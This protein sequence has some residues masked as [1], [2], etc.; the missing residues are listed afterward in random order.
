MCGRYTLRDPAAVAEV[1]RALGTEVDT[2]PPVPRFNAA[3]SQTMPAVLGTDTGPRYQNLRWGIVPFFARKD[4]KPLQLINARS[5][6]A[7]EKPSF[8][9]SIQK[10]RC[11]LPAD[12]FFEWKREPEGRSK[13]PFFIRRRD[14]KP[15]L[16]AGIYEEASDPFP[17]G[18]ALLTTGPNEL[19]EPIHH[20]M[21]VILDL[22]AARSWLST[23]PIEPDQVRTICVSYPAALMRADPVSPIVNN[24][25]NDSPDCV[26]P[27]AELDFS[28]EWG[29]PDQG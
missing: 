7:A 27:L 22:E 19:M 14:E 13:T 17:A 26:R 12:G 10:R 23:G 16:I 11:V 21:P 6:T 20:R 9:Q 5:E 2:P 18:F 3:P 24:A 28:K 15:F 8:R 29:R 25:R 1:I 4:P